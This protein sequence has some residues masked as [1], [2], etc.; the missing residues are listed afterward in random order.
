MPG[1]SARAR[2]HN[3]GKLQNKP[4]TKAKA[5]VR[6]DTTDKPATFVKAQDRYSGEGR[7]K[8]LERWRAKTS[9]RQEAEA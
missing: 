7:E 4:R 6:R 2:E 3:E 5:A 1:G 9:H 8:L